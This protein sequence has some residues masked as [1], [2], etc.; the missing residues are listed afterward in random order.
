MTTKAKKQEPV[1]VEAPAQSDPYEDGV[2]FAV[3]T[4][5][6]IVNEQRDAAWLVEKAVRD[7]S[8]E[9]QQ[10][11]ADIL[12]LVPAQNQAAEVLYARLET[13]MGKHLRE[14]WQMR[15]DLAKKEGA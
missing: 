8:P 3:A 9:K 12:R 13:R 6:A 1:R 11:V 4:L 15:R 2:L 10:A 14:R 7:V 5:L